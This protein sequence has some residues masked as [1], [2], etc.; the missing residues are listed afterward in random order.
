[1]SY[2]DITITCEDKDFTVTVV[3]RCGCVP[4]DKTLHSIVGIAQTLKGSVRF[5]YG[6]IYLRNFSSSVNDRFGH[7]GIFEV[8]IENNAHRLVVLTDN[9]YDYQTFYNHS[10]HV[11][12][13]PNTLTGP[14]FLFADVRYLVKNSTTYSAAADTSMDFFLKNGDAFLNLKMEGSHYYTA[15]SQFYI[16]SNNIRGIAFC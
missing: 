15:D 9:V 11:I 3:S 16:V 12:H 4:C 1:M 5:S 2:E 8:Q 10:S 13:L 14:E 6:H 7:S